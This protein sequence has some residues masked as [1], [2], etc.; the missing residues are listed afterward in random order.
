[1]WRFVH[2]SLT[3]RGLKW[4]SLALA[5]LFVVMVGC[6]TPA[7]NTD[8]GSKTP[9][10][11]TNNPSNPTEDK[12]GQMAKVD[13][14]KDVKP[15]LTNFCGQCHTGASAKDGVDITVLTAADKDK[16]AKLAEEVEAGK[17]PPPKAAKQPTT[18]ERAKLVA[19]LKAL[20]G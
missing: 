18:E 3:V 1:M 14:E 15:N 19:D 6:T 4:S 12:G 10:A 7:E 17:M 11:G 16:F 5:A 9:E 13:F 20:A 2:N 8:S